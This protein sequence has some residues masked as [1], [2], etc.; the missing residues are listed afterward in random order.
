MIQPVKS[1]LLVLMSF[2]WMSGA[3]SVHALP[4]IQELMYDA[5]GADAP[6]VFTELSGEADFDLTGWSLVGINGFNGQIYR[7][8]SLTGAV[9]PPDG[10]LVIATSS[11]TGMYLTER[12]W[13]G[14]VDWQNGP[15]A[16]HLV[17]PGGIV[18]DALQYGDAGEF[19]AGEGAWAPDVLAGQSLARDYLSSDT[20]NNFADFRVVDNPTPGRIPGGTQPVPEPAT[21]LLVG[22]GFAGLRRFARRPARGE[23]GTLHKKTAV[24]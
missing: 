13:I 3:S 2:A 14:S 22:L 4:L 18:V 20:H 15:D 8:V 17:D 10:I 12:D 9:I 16:V 5:V 7:T 24:A 11:A 23:D 1:G 6:S 21:I 19:G